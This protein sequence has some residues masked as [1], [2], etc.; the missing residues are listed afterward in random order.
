MEHY[1]IARDAEGRTRLE[2]PYRGTRLLQHPL[3]TKGTAFTEEERFAFG[4]EGLLPHHTSPIEEQEER[5]YE[6]IVRKT[7]PLEKYVGLAA[8]QDRN[9]RLFY[10]L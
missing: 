4:L 3:Y 9:E 2:C 6:N 7:D 1:G 8:L 5:V 10:R